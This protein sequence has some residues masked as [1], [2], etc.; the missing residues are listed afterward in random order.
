M[1]DDANHTMLNTTMLITCLGRQSVFGIASG[2]GNARVS[3]LANGSDY[4]LSGRAELL[5][6]GDS[7]HTH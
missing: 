4:D 6:D 3:Q 5:Q 2:V 7:G 1:V